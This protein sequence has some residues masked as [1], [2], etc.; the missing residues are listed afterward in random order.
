MGRRILTND[1]Y[2]TAFAASEM[3]ATGL[4]PSDANES[5]LLLVLPPGAYTT[6][7]SGAEGAMGVALTEVFEVRPPVSAPQV[8]AST[9]FREQKRL[10]APAMAKRAETP[11]HRVLE[12]CGAPLV[13]RLEQK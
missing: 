5:A 12:I 10:R 11:I 7:V 6:V 2:S 1:N 4:A 8:A 3:P 13:A 9:I